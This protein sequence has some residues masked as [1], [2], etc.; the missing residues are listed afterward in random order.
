M[1]ETFFINVWEIPNVGI[2]G[3]GRTATSKPW[4]RDIYQ[5]KNQKQKITKPNRYIELC[6]LF[7][8]WESVFRF[9]ELT[10]RSLDLNT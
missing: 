6:N 8:D 3:R 1:S 4:N 7:S 10:A 5:N 9:L 2:C